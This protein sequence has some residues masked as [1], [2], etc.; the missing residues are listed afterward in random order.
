MYARF[1]QGCFPY[2]E[3]VAENQVLCI[4]PNTALV[5]LDEDDVEGNGLLG[6]KF[7]II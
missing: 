4:E 1:A 6:K 2:Y 3:V 5:T 7:F